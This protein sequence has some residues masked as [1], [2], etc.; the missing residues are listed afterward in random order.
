MALK[1]IISDFT[2]ITEWKPTTKYNYSNLNTRPN[3]QT[4]ALERTDKF[5][6]IY[7]LNAALARAYQLIF[8]FILSVVELCRDS[9]VQ[10]Q[11]AVMLDT[12]LFSP[13]KGSCTC[14]FNVTGDYLDISHLESPEQCGSKINFHLGSTKSPSESQSIDCTTYTTEFN[15]TVVKDG[16]L[17]LSQLETGAVVAGFCVSMETDPNGKHHDFK[18]F[19]KFTL[20]MTI[21][22]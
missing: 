17:V 12:S 1:I 4:Q 11:H 8:N 19:K 20:V 16:S 3:Q 14:R 5:L 22:S 10:T 9:A 6:Y 21:L 18:D 15:T 2:L 7:I 13:G